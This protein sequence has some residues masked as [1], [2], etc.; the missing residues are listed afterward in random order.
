MITIY[1][2]GK[3]GLC[4]REITYYKRIAP[5]GLFY[6]ADIAH[7][8][9]ALKP[10][11]ISQADALRRLHGIDE[12]GA[13]HVGVDAFVLI[14]RQLSYWR[15]FGVMVSLPGVRQIAG[16]VYDRFA[17]YRFMRLDHCQIAADDALLDR[18]K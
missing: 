6:W 15:I 13:L 3:C 8:P 9:S 18:Q 4:S 17:D 10:L 12:H 1:F 2:D 16:W 5:E 11:K 14:W 7:D